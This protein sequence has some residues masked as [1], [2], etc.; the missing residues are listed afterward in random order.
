MTMTAEPVSIQLP[1]LHD[2]Q[3]VIA[4]HPAR[5]KVVCCGRRWGKTLLGMVLAL[6]VA[7][8]GGRVWWVAP[9]YKQALEGW[10]YLLR[11]AIKVE[12][13]VKQAELLVTFATGGTIQVRTGDTPD[14]LRGAGLDLVVL[15]EAAMMKADVWDLAIRPALAD[16]RGEALFISTP[17]HFNW[18]FALF[19]RGESADHPDWAS[20]QKPTWD[21]PFIDEDEIDS[22]RAE[23]DDDDFEQEFAASFTAIGGAVFKMLGANR[24]IFLRPMPP[25]LEFV[26]TGV[27]M[28]WGTTPQHK[29]AV[30]CGSRLKTGV[31]WYRSRWE[32][33]EGGDAAWFTEA[34]RCKVD[35]GATFARV[36]RSQSR[37]RKSVV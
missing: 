24:P 28:D 4:K 33:Y 37:D 31:I 6:R 11:L 34:K 29:A 18:F 27:G 8:K 3:R 17:K 2:S 36:D 22:A 32:D 10:S 13:S 20:W 1:P 5:F 23:M 30:V 12:S 35:H 9:T 26:R 25:G 14:N 15:D 21:N 16:R 19:S 7:L